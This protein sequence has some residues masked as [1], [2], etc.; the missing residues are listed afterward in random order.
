MFIVYTQ[1]AWLGIPVLESTLEPADSLPQE[2]V[3]D[4]ENGI[5]KEVQKQS[6][7]AGGQTIHTLLVTGALSSKKRAKIDPSNFVSNS[8]G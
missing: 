2:L 3:E 4:F 7:T 6:I 1:V 5:T 8:S